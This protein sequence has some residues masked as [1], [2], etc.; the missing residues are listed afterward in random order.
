MATATYPIQNSSFTS[1]KTPD[2]KDVFC[3]RC[4]LQ[5]GGRA[6]GTCPKCIDDQ[7]II[8]CSLRARPPL[9]N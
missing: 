6:R 1:D 9:H 4:G 3:V 2:I 5:M 8:R 7:N